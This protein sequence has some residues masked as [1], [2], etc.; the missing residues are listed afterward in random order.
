MIDQ[1]EETFSV[2]SSVTPE[3]FTLDKVDE[4]GASK[5]ST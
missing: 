3:I 1:A 5:R 4:H 2:E